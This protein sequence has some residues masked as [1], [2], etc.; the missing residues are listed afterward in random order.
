M[1]RLFLKLQPERNRK[2]DLEVLEQDFIDDGVALRC[3]FE[4][5]HILALDQLDEVLHELS[6]LK[7]TEKF[8]FELAFS[9]QLELHKFP[10]DEVPI[11]PTFTL[12]L[13]TKLHELVV[14]SNKQRV[15][16]RE[17]LNN[18]SIRY[19][20][21]REEVRQCISPWVELCDFLRG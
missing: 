21:M 3:S 12:N 19:E 13:E 6:I 5:W 17:L 10:E 11:I 4:A 18:S 2:N 9:E 16:P 8:I 14:K 15:W 20:I 7:I 1:L